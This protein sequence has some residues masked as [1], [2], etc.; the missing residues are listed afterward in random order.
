[1]QIM[2]KSLLEDL[3]I[4]VKAIQENSENA[5]RFSD[6]F[7]ENYMSLKEDQQLDG[8][9]ES[10]RSEF[11][12]DPKLLTLV[13]SIIYGVVRDDRSLYEI[14]YLLQHSDMDLLSQIYIRDQLETCI[15][16]NSNLS[17]NFR[18]N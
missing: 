2:I 9:Y 14:F 13:L 6:L 5:K 18:N 3:N 16:R 17:V 10:L 4:Y 11:S 8:F 1:M 15:F 7:R 12:S